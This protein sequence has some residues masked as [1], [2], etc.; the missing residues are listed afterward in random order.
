MRTAPT[1]PGGSAAREFLREAAW[2]TSRSAAP[3]FAHHSA[4][5]R[6]HANDS[7]VSDDGR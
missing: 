3:R 6:E 4:G 5:R 7:I 1:P 2:I